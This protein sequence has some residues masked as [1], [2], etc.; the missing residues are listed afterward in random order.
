MGPPRTNR[1]DLS[2]RSPS[3]K[4]C[5]G[6]HRV[7]AKL[8]KGKTGRKGI[9]RKLPEP[10][11]ADVPA[12]FP[13]CEECIGPADFRVWKAAW[14]KSMEIVTDFD[15]AC[16]TCVSAARKVYR[17]SIRRTKAD[18]A[19]PVRTREDSYS[20]RIFMKQIAELKTEMAS[21]QGLVEDE[22][23]K[24]L[25]AQRALGWANASRQ[26]N[27]LKGFSYKARCAR[28]CT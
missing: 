20:A 3:P 24:R 1:H 2:F 8:G 14:A 6:C 4:V 5:C 18:P 9:T 25:D 11:E 21:L 28:A 23:G 19:S 27:E 13:Q 15:R 16:K 17:S 26:V 7:P 22:K 10:S 12:P